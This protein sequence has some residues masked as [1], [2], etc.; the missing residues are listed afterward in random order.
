MSQVFVKRC[1]RCHRVAVQPNNPTPPG[2][3][4]LAD[5]Q[6]GT[7][8]SI[9]ICPECQQDMGL[10]VLLQKARSDR[11]TGALREWLATNDELVA[12]SINVEELVAAIERGEFDAAF[13][14]GDGVA[15]EDEIAEGEIVA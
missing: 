13:D 8:A 5:M 7:L 4:C 9:D 3:Q 1:D 12:D 14:Q 11:A 2:W 10:R 6:Y 15:A